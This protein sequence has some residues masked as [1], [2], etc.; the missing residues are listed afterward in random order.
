MMVFQ[1]RD[2]LVGYPQGDSSRGIVAAACAGASGALATCV[3]VAARAVAT[4]AVADT[5]A[6]CALAIFECRH[7]ACCRPVVMMMCDI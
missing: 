1:H 2:G 7:V 3:A 4:C 5:P 6:T